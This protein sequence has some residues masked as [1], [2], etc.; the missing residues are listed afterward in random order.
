MVKFFFFDRKTVRKKPFLLCMS[1]YGAF[2]L[3]NHNLSTTIKEIQYV[4]KV[5][6]L[7]YLFVFIQR[8]FF[9]I[10]DSTNYDLHNK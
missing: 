6:N 1:T 7:A 2:V 5:K 8:R 10:S 4:K 9:L 3:I